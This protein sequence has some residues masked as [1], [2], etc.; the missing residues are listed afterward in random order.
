MQRREMIEE[1]LEKIEDELD[2]LSSA[3]LLSLVTEYEHSQILD[4]VVDGL[5]LDLADDDD[6]GLVE[7][8][9]D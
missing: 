8:E 6:T 1:L 9:E 4:G 5:A 3:Q 2:E 7:N